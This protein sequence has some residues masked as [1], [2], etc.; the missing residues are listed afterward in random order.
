MPYDISDAQI[1]TT[2]ISP[3]GYVDV[4]CF[5]LYQDEE[6]LKDQKRNMERWASEIKDA[7]WH[8]EGTSF[9]RQNGEFYKSIDLYHKCGV[10][11]LMN[12]DEVSWFTSKRGAKK[13]RPARPQ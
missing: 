2:W 10:P 1:I 3:Y 6:F 13:R 8:I 12:R 11:M 9:F 7:G 5:V 4:L